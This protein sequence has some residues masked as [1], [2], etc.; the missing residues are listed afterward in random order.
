MITILKKLPMAICGMILGIASLGNLFISLQMKTIGTFF[1]ILSI[2]LMFF[3]LLKVLLTFNHAVKEITNPISA[4][5]LPTFTMG[6]MVIATYWG[7]WGFHTFA[8]IIWC[9]AII[10]QLTITAV[11]VYLHLIKPAVGIEH[12]YPSWFVTFVGFGVAPVT[13]SQ[14]IPSIGRA[15]LY[16]ALGLYIILLPI[17]IYRLVKHHEMNEGVLPFITIVAAPASLCLTGYLNSFT[18]INVPFAIG[19][20]ILAQVLYLSTLLTMARIYISAKH[21]L[22]HFFPSFAAFT[23]P[24]VISATGLFTLL[25]RFPN[26][27]L[28]P[29]LTGLAYLELIIAVVVIV[30][31]L[32]HYL[33][34][35][36]QQVSE[37]FQA[38][39]VKK[40]VTQ[41]SSH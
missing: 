34:F 39:S 29:T 13:A 32:G 41:H 9:T 2:I 7:N 20:G 26:A 18:T 30:F 27:T 17:V 12:V 25:K 36:R 8:L 21:S 5:T 10:V 3:V 28:T 1:G 37:Y 22:L 19:L 6:L 4:A 31:V 33:H 16:L 24:L 35:I 11:F 38:S 40:P 15:L 14:F 23:F